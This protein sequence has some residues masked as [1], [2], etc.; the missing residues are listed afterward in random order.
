[1]KMFLVLA[2]MSLSVSANASMY[3]SNQKT[4]S[5]LVSYNKDGAHYLMERPQADGSVLVTKLKITKQ[6]TLKDF[7]TVNGVTTETLKGLAYTEKSSP[8]IEDLKL[9]RSSNLTA[10]VILSS[11]KVQN[12]ET[13]FTCKYVQD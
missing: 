8:A 1:M 2:L 6:T 5:T 3:C 4:G 13:Q 12:S 11:D 7:E 10:A 9:L